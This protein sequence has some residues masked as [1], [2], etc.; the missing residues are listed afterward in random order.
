MQQTT[1]LTKYIKKEYDHQQ[2]KC[3]LMT[4]D[5]LLNNIAHELKLVLPEL[6][7]KNED[8]LVIDFKALVI[9]NINM[10]HSVMWLRREKE[11][12]LIT[13]LILQD[14]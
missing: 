3:F 10:Q 12:K 2:K 4:L 8:A 14:D 9:Q 1:L 6:E 11:R 7:M 13:I 5:L